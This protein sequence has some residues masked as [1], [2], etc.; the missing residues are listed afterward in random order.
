MNGDRPRAHTPERTAWVLERIRVG[1][2]AA[3]AA[4]APRHKPLTLAAFVRHCPEPRPCYND[5]ARLGGWGAALISA[6]DGH[7]PLAV[8]LEKPPTS[9]HES[10]QPSSAAYKAVVAVDALADHRA[11]REA[12]AWRTER[13][14]LLERLD[15]AERR[16]AHQ[17]ALDDD[18]TPPSIQRRERA[19]GMREA[20]AIVLASDW[21]VEETVDPATVNNLNAY[22]LSIAQHRA[23]RFFDGISWLLDAHATH[24]RIRDLVLWLGGDLITGTIHE[25]LLE[26]NG[27]SPLLASRFVRSLVVE[28]IRMLLVSHPELERIVIPCSHGNHGRTTQKPRISTGAHNSYEHALYLALSD[29]FREEPRVR[30]HV[31]RGEL[32]YINVYDLSVRFTHGDA[33]KYAG[34]VGGITIPINKAVAA[35]DRSIRADLTCMGHWHQL[36][37]GSKCIVNGSLIG[38]SAYTVRIKAEMEEGRQAFALVD[39]RHGVCQQTPVW[40]T[41]SEPQALDPNASAA[42]RDGLAA[43]RT[44]RAA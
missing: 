26:S 24:F 7:A 32:V 18:G 37:F 33:V 10:P 17:A 30:F 1:W 14:E 13:R 43:S 27:L 2:H 9:V 36:T 35:W 25:E 3:M 19:S 41:P 20:T 28:G 42:I 23:R 40:T 22:D 6:L 15:E 12:S 39:S 34:G 38:P 31:A 5:L 21:H 8:P 44:S 29:D 16:A 11:D 4:G